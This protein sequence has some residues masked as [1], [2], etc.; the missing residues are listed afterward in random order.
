MA[1]PNWTD[2]ERQEKIMQYGSREDPD[3][4][5][6]VLGSHGDSQS[7]ILVLRKLMAATDDDPSTEFNTDEYWQFSIKDTELDHRQA[8][9]LDVLVPPPEHRQYK[10]TWIGA[11]IGYT[12]DPTEILIFAE[13]PMSAEE[14]RECKA[15]GKSVPIDGASR[16]KLIG[17]VTLRRIDAPAQ[18]DVIEELVS[19]YNPQGFAMDAGG[20]GLPLFQIIQRRMEDADRAEQSTRSRKAA[21]AIK[22]YKFDQKIV[23]E[24][25]ETVELPENVTMQER[26]KE[27]G[28]EQRV[29]EAST[30]VIRTYVDEGRIWLPWDTEL[31]SELQGQSYSYSKS[32]MDRYGRRRRVFSQGNFHAFDA[33][34]FAMIGHK[35]FAIEALINQREPETGPVLDMAIFRED[36]L[37]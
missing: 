26:I 17:R 20:N 13:Y 6:N 19:F 12:I 5:R 8:N 35:Q 16:I 29:L 28:I 21:E 2:E 9:I 14:K 30:D 11:D 15:R 32:E 18:A 36:M 33:F 4:R 3:Y 31:L 1:R 27:A 25:D 34:R 10:T 7:P 24:F 37:Y 23:V 22:G